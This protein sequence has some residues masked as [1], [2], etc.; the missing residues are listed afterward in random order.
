MDRQI[1]IV[2]VILAA[3]FVIFPVLSEH[4]AYYLPTTHQVTIHENGVTN[5]AYWGV[6][7]SQTFPGLS[8]DR[9]VGTYTSSS[10]NI[11]LTLPYGY[12][13]V[14]PLKVGG[15]LAKQTIQRVH[16]SSSTVLPPNSF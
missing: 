12:Y 2:V 8:L 6:N 11:S 13:N 4:Y 10:P 9:Y 16:V 5:A 7:I 3:N 1:K 14:E 15:F